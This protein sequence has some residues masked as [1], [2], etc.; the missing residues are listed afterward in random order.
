MA[1]HKDF[2]PTIKA[3]GESVI[4]R[5]MACFHIDSV[6]CPSCCPGYQEVSDTGRWSASGFDADEWY[7]T[8]DF[9]RAWGECVSARDLYP[10]AYRIYKTLRNPASIKTSPETMT[11]LDTLLN[12]IGKL[13][14]DE[15]KTLQAKLGEEKLGE[16]WKPNGADFFAVD[17]PSKGP[18]AKFIP[19]E[20]WSKQWEESVEMWC[21]DIVGPSADAVM[22]E[23]NRTRARR[24]L[25]RIAEQ[26]NVY[27]EPGEY[28]IAKHKR[29]DQFFAL[30][31]QCS[32]AAGEIRFQG[33]EACER[34]IQAM[35]DDIKYLFY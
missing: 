17:Y 18:M 1:Y 3:S 31:T 34:A 19:A 14:P 11:N 25:Q 33:K 21:A 12:A 27:S 22:L 32:P 15:L 5:P 13:T 24:K 7:G 28:I 4:N 29:L 6:R 8:Q 9:Y 2:P 16:P 23:A 10:N 20:R 26:V 30:H 35:G